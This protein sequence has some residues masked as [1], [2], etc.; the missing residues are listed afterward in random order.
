MSFM[1]GSGSK[2]RTCIHLFVIVLH[3]FKWK[4]VKKEN[5]VTIAK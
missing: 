3:C 4:L 1:I 2:E 5:V